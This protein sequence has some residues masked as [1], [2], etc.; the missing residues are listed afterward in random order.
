MNKVDIFAFTRVFPPE[1]LICQLLY[2][3]DLQKRR[4]RCLQKIKTL[5]HSEKIVQASI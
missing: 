2:S 1:E 5:I 3:K 4:K